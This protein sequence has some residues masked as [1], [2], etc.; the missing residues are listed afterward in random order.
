MK[1]CLARTS[2]LVP[3]ATLALAGCGQEAQGPGTA[4]TV[5]R[6]AD[7]ASGDRLQDVGDYVVH[8]NA[9]TT[10]QLPPDVAR[11]YGITRSKGRAMVNVVIIKKV[12]GTI[13]KPVKGKVEIR[14]RNLTGQAKNL[15]LREITE[16]EAI[17]YIGD[18]PV[19][20]G[21]TL[22]YDVSVTPEGQTE[23]WNIRFKQ[24]FF[25]E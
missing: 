11:A 14:T 24:Q 4:T 3:L 18:V 10:D 23:T 25:T 6:T 19:I 2:I 8:Y 16:E 9:L 20:D 15:S 13:G 7:D 22:V 21:E 1:R 12:P 5:D 17:Y